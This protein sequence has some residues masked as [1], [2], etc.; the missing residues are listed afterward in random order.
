MIR[1]KADRGDRGRKLVSPASNPKIRRTTFNPKIVCL[2][3]EKV[4]ETAYY[5]LL[6]TGD[7][8]L[9]ENGDKLIM[10]Y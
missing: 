6:E 5:I 8:L 9:M 10:E 3:Y 4:D 7:K 2:R 1:V